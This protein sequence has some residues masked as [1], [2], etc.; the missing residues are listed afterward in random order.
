ML[1]QT[2]IVCTIGPATSSETDLRALIEAGMNVARLNF[3]HGDHAQHLAVLARIRA[4]AERLDAPVAVLQDLAGPKVRIGTVAGG[5][6][7]LE[8]GH[9]LVLTT[10]P[11]EGSTSRVSVSY[12]NL[13][14][15]VEAGDGL[16]LADGTIQLRVERVT[17]VE[18]HCRV[19][20]GG[21]LGSRKG[22][23][24]PSGLSGL[25]VLGAKDLDDL[26]FGLEQGVDYVGLSFV[27]SAEDV[28]T[29]RAHIEA[30]GGQAP[31]IAKIETQA[32]LDHFDA[33]ADAADG[34]MIARGDLSLETPFTRVPVVQKQLIA[35][36]NRRAKPVI[37]A[38]QMLYSMVSFPQP[39]RAEVADVANAILDGSDAVMLSEETAVGEHP[40]RAVEV[41]A[42]IARATEGG[43]L[44]DAPS[45]GAMEPPLTGE[46]AVVQAA[47]QLGTRL[48]SDV[49]VTI[50]ATGETARFAARCRTR[51]PILA[52]T[53]DRNTYRRLALVRG[54]VPLLLPAP[55]GAAAEPLETA[56]SVLHERGWRGKRAVLAAADR[57]WRVTL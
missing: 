52:L 22:V 4:L 13:P 34:I 54:V 38:T 37:T 50:T 14:R 18:I 25:P 53:G 49:I 26:R 43:V 51:Q 39:T 44:P 27:R 10:D 19:V 29:A 45:P 47:C 40:V 6:I 31:V 2:K 33:I 36:A 57:V 20:A 7:L 42:A 23:N 1:R 5:S 15:E 41:M 48:R 11:V 32:A 21:R 9:P 55:V 16:L 17:E 12:A 28:H 24:V 46:E 30:L 3:A 8:A 56:R 35:K